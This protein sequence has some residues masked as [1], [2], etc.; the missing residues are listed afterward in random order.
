MVFQGEE[1]FLLNVVQSS[2]LLLGLGWMKRGVG[3]L[4]LGGVAEED[5][6]SYL[7]TLPARLP[8]RLR[9]P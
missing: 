7:L 3:W 9:Q 6:I 5:L 8:S 2:G 1:G 4:G